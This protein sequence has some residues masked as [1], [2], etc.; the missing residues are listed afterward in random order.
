MDKVC[1]LRAGNKK[2]TQDFGWI[3]SWET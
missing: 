2:Y 3:I 1:N